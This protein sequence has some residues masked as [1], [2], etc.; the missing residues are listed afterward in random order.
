MNGI[1]R[2]FVVEGG[3]KHTV[4]FRLDS[5]VSYNV[6]TRC[7]VLL[8]GRFFVHKDSEETVIRAYR[9]LDSFDVVC[10]R[11][12]KLGLSKDSDVPSGGSKGFGGRFIKTVLGR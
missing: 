10:S 4:A 3:K 1:V 2:I 8:S 5:F 11:N 12:E 6:D 7:L 9:M